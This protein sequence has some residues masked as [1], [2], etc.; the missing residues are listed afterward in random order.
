MIKVIFLDLG[1]V[2]IDFD[3][4]IPLAQ[5][6][7]YSDLPMPK[8]KELISKTDV[9][10]NFDMGMFS[11]KDFYTAMVR[12]L[13][14]DISK[15]DFNNLWNSLFLPV[16]LLSE[17]L[18]VDL[19][20]YYPVFLLSNTNEIHFKF[21]WQHYPIV[22]HIENHLLSYELKKM[23][24]NQSIY[25]IAISRS[26]VLPKEIFFADDR[27][28]NVEGAK[29]AGINATLF[30]SESQLKIAMRQAGIMID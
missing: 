20:H 8:I 13:K 24:P 11:E 9:L 27:I 4:A 2:I 29:T 18:L 19:T 17:T 22:R 15:E 26:G 7:H 10:S 5:L 1:K 14:L 16:P 25:Q 21:I 6:T 28:E 30:E 12:D 23:K 3:P